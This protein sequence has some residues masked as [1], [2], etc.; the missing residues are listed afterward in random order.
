MKTTLILAALLSSCAHSDL[1]QDG[2]KVAHF[3]GDMTGLTYRRFADGKIEMNGTIR[4]SD[5]TIA[6]GKA[7]AGAILSASG[8]VTLI[9]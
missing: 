5:A 1:Y 3:E 9:K 4:H 2:K 6:S 8:L 7:G